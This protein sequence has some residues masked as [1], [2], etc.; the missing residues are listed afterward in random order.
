MAATSSE[1]T[2]RPALR[3]G[4]RFDPSGGPR[5]IPLFEE[6]YKSY[7]ADQPVLRGMSLVIERGEFVFITGPSGAGKSTLLRLVHRT[8]RADDGRILFLG[9]DIARLSEDLVPALR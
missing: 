7:R 1:T 5:P 2:F 9:R 8:E 6:V 4:P 3:K